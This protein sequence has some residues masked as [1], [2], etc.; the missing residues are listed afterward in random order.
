MWSVRTGAFCAPG[1]RHDYQR[2]R[3]AYRA[4]GVANF[5]GHCAAGIILLALFRHRAAHTAGGE[6]PSAHGWRD[7]RQ[8]PLPAQPPLS[9]LV[10]WARSLSH[11]PVCHS[12]VD[13]P[14]CRGGPLS[15]AADR[16]RFWPYHAADSLSLFAHGLFWHGADLPAVIFARALSHGAPGLYS[17]LSRA[18]ES[19]RRALA[20]L[21]RSVCP[22]H[23]WSRG[24]FHSAATGRW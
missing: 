15:V 16:T 11:L 19:F 13:D 17:P 20:G 18:F 6:R 3:R 5:A 2:G 10:G 9:F 21:C 7:T 1:P 14:G 8:G 12:R 4:R 24:R 23:G 22:D